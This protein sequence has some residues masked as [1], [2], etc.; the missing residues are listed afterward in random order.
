LPDDAGD[1]VVAAS[2]READDDVNRPAR[3]FDLVGSMR[4]GE[5][6]QTDSGQRQSAKG[7]HDSIPPRAKCIVKRNLVHGEQA[8]IAR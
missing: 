2:R 8:E 1:D 5:K 7:F 4:D 3:I 6:A